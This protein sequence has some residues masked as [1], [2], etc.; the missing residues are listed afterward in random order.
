MKKTAKLQL[1]LCVIGVGAAILALSGCPIDAATALAWG[2]VDELEP[3]C[4][5]A[6]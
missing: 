6:M 4:S 1:L 5:G 2:L 3:R